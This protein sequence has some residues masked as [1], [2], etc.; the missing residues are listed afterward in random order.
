[1][2]DELSAELLFEISQIDRLLDESKPLFD[3]CQQKTPGYIEMA[4]CAMTLQSFYHG[5]ESILMLIFKHYDESLPKGGKW[6]ADLLDKAVVPGKKR[7][8]IFS[9]DLQKRLD[10]YLRFRHFT[11]NS[12][13]FQ[14][15]WD[16]MSDLVIGLN[17]LWET[18]K[19]DIQTFIKVSP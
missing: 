16:R 2:D 12:Y 4:A 18:A 5:I 14:Y 6:H 19:N 8:P 11:R 3:S 15:K 10:V 17:D 9:S 13:G 7:K 1:M